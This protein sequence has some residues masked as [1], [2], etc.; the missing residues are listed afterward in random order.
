MWGDRRHDS[1]YIEK[2]LPLAGDEIVEKIADNV[3][4][5]GRIE[6]EI[7]QEKDTPETPHM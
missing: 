3:L 2:D 5:W 1:R 4:D 7:A 6:E